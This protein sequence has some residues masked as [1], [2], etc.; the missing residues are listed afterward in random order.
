MNF[1]QFLDYEAWLSDV[2]ELKC[3]TEKREITQ[4]FCSMM[5]Y[6]SKR[7]AFLAVSPVL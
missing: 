3:T 1:S 6:M 7:K 4:R 5:F 2:A